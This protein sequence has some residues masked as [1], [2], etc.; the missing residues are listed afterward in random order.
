MQQEE[1][2]DFTP[3]AENING[4][5]FFMQFISGDGMEKIV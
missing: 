3:V 1:C 2:V 4:A 5:A